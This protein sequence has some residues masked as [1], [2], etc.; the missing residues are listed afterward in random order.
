MTASTIRRVVY[1]LE[2]HQIELEMQNEELRRSEVRL[3]DSRDHLSELYDFAPVGYLTLSSDATIVAMNLAAAATLGVE[4]NRTLGQKFTRY[5]DPNAQDAFY[6]HQRSASPGSPTRTVELLL[7]TKGSK[8][9]IVQMDMACVRDSLTTSLSWYTAISDVS[10]RKRN[11]E[12]VH[13][14]LQQAEMAQSA[15]E[16]ANQ[17]KS[18][19]LANMSHE[20]RTP[21]NG[22]LGMTEL[23]LGTTLDAE[24]RRFAHVAHHSGEALLSLVND[25]LDLSKIE[26]GKLELETVPFDPRKIIEDVATLFIECAH[27]KDL[28]LSWHIDE[29]VPTLAIGDPGRLRQIIANLVS[30]A[31]KFTEAGQI[32]IRLERHGETHTHAAGDCMFR[33]TVAD[34]GIGMSEEVRAR[35]F[36]PFSQADSSITRR[37]GGTGLGLAIAKQLTEAMGGTIEVASEPGKGTSFQFSARLG[38]CESANGPVTMRAQHDLYGRRGL[39]VKADAIDSAMKSVRHDVIAIRPLGPSES[40]QSAV[41]DTARVLLAEDNLVNQAVA[42]AMLRK[43]GYEMDIA[44]NGE[45]A[46]TAAAR[47]DYDLI[48]MDCQMP[49]MDGLE[50]T[51]AIRAREAIERSGA[52]VPIVALTANA[53]KVEHAHCIAAGMD[54]YIAKPYTILQLQLILQKYL[55]SRPSTNVAVG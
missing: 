18:Q 52:C 47:G 13:Q 40:K 31:I 32:N 8:P 54:D 46:V 11:E 48:L 49:V 12:A 15:A 42:R 7:R 22:I 37:Y 3:A 50:A 26:A 30:N 16:F 25:V 2:V 21:L 6:L 44:L 45:E 35:L 43:L 4:R 39:I 53:A 24:Q 38:I 28:E 51:A 29:D 10:E 9:V 17:A 33:L 14:A 23:L 19:F 34:T 41:P 1:E 27:A 36:R 20:L 55:S 5:I